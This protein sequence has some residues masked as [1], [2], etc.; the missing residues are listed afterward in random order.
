MTVIHSLY[1]EP[2]TVTVDR[3][4]CKQCGQCALICPTEVLS[5]E[6]GQLMVHQDTYLG[7]IACG[8]C[9]MVCPEGSISV[10]GRGISPDDLLPM[11]TFDKTTAADTF[12]A[13]LQT[14][15]SIRRFKEKEVEPEVLNRVLELAAFGPMG[16]PPWEVGCVVVQGRKNVQNLAEQI[17]NGY[18]GLLRFMKPW[19]L[20]FMKPFMKKTTF[21]QFSSFILPLAQMYVD[22]YRQGKD[23]LF[24]D[25][26]AVM[27]FYRSAYTETTDTA[28]AC[29][30][31]MVAAESLGLGTTMIGGA[32]PMMKRNKKLCQQL[33]IPEGNTPEIAL[34]LGYPAAHFRKT[35][36]RRFTGIK[37]NQNK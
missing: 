14:R 1:K 22:R 15:R 13:I 29:T 28:I 5:M 19:V 9:M 12:A 3:A 17:I 16:I 36:R 23:V 2:G 20:S 24:Y 32:A 27:L 33:G 10:T 4:T 37:I 21:E 30:Y 8:H 35:I 6:E 34:I 26:P 7:C 11:P 25:A 31:A 18:S